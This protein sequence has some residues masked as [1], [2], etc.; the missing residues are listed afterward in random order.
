MYDSASDSR[1]LI[2]VGDDY[3]DIELQYPK[4][5]LLESGAEVVLAGLKS[6]VPHRGKHGTIE[7]TQVAIDDIDVDRIDALIVPGGWMPD[8]LRRFDDVK[9]I[10]KEVH[11]QGKVVASICHG[12]WIPISAGI[13]GGMTYT[14]SPGVADDLTNAGAKWVDESVV[15]DR[16]HVSSRRPDDLPAFCK[17]I[18][19]LLSTTRRSD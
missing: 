6:G 2:F 11:D 4:Y 1:V 3:E 18:L 7:H 8:W 17:A 16:N 19:G 9:R 10:T 13:V 12:P 15:V 14:S 5:R